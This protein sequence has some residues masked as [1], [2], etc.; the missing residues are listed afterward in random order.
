MA[1]PTITCPK[2][3]SEIKLTESLA[4]PLLEA[5]RKRFA[6][7]LANKDAEVA[8]RE[9]GLREQQAAID[10]AREQIEARIADRLEIERVDAYAA[11]RLRRWLQFKHQTRGRR[12]GYYLA[13]HLYEHFGLV[14]LSAPKR[15]LPWAKA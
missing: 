2:C 1:D 9:A 12:G 11:M 10:T 4:A 5:T 8:K 13:S 14:H 7:Q 6:E 15:D 3:G